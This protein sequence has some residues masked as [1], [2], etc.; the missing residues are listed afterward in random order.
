[1]M[2]TNS[3]RTAFLTLCLGLLMSFAG[4]ADAGSP[5]PA[6]AA[7][8]ASATS[9]YEAEISEWRRQR[10]ARLA[11][12]SG[13][14]TLV[15]MEW[16]QEGVN[17]LG[18]GDDVDIRVP[19]GPAEWGTIT[20][21]GEELVF[22][23]YAGADVAVDGLPASQ[24]RLVPDAE[25]APTVISSGNL[26]MYVILRGSYALR[27]KDRQAP[28][29][30]AFTGIDTY[31]ID[32]GWRFNA[33]FIPAEP[34]QTIE[35]AN[36]LGQIEQMAVGG[37]AEFDRDGQSYRLLGLETDAGD[38]LWFLFAD[39]TSGRETYGA[40]RFLYSDGLPAD[41]RLVVD[42]NKAYNPPC[43]F[44]DYSTCPLPPQQNRLDLAVTAG[45]K[46]F[47]HD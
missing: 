17:R 47:H 32:S 20:V 18:S 2:E 7:M 43:A 12:D 3:G 37:F 45:E 33:R 28:T 16:L 36:V 46:D 19:G 5:E 31:P 14:L 4:R 9:E 21:R 38:S 8:T 44:S 15:G 11:S 1:M 6:V 41:G 29:L 25:G 22:D 39:R 35:I 23:A 24:T 26:S 30:L 42:F 40:G 10:H 13:W 34:G 27:I